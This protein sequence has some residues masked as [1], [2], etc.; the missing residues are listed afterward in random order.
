[1]VVILAEKPDQ[2]RK[3]ASPFPHRRQKNHIE[4][5]HCSL[6]KQGAT[7]VWAIGH[8]VT[9][10]EPERY[11]SNWKKWNLHDLPLIPESFQHQIVAEK[12][13]HYKEIKKHLLS[14]SEII[15]ATDPA[16]EGELIARWIIQMAG[17]TRK[18]IKRLW[19]SSLTSD[20]IIQAFQNLRTGKSTEP[21]YH[22]ALARSYSD[23]LV[24]MNASRVYTLLLQAKG[25]AGVF[26][27]G[28]VQT[29]LLTLIRKRE[30]EIENFKPE[31][32]W[33]LVGEFHTENEDLYTG[34]HRKRFTDRAEAYA[35]FE[36]LQGLPGVITDVTADLKRIAPPKLHSLS[37]LQTKMNRRFK[38]SPTQILNVVQGLYEKGY[39]SYPRTDSQYVGKAEA[40]T[41][42]ELLARLSA[43][44][45]I[46][47][48]PQK[49]LQNKRYVNDAKVTDHHAILPTTQ[50]PFLNKLNTN[51]RQVY[52]EIARSF[53][54]IHAPDYR[55]RETIIQTTVENVDFKSVG[56][57][58]IDFGWKKYLDEVKKEAKKDEMILPSVTKGEKVRAHISPKEG[59]TQAPKPYTEGQLIQLMKT[60]G[61]HIEDENIESKAIGLGT[62]ATRAGMI[63]TLKDR[64][65]IT[66]SKN[67]VMVTEK[68]KT[69]V[70]A[71]AGTP[72]AKP[73][74]TAKWEAYLIEIGQGKR[75]H[76]PFIERSK[77][78]AAHLVKHA[79]AQ[80]K[81][82]QIEVATTSAITSPIG[83]CPQCQQPLVAHQ[84]FY[85]CSG[86]RSGCKFSLPK[87]YCKK[88]ISPATV[89]RLLTKGKSNLLKGFVSKQGN[90]FDAFLVLKDGKIAF[91]FAKDHSTKSV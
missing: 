84:K 12:A 20:A 71:I 18:P 42:P 50:L 48:P 91:D 82:W 45:A 43:S 67:T 61:K 41:F 64:D 11:E 1:M 24:G 19:S 25:V 39:V 47:D 13:H 54:A 36:R 31:H 86:Y 75:S 32:F 49:V 85:G 51:E 77:A 27:A 52:D 60:A 15:I 88:K 34:K 7:V 66:V 35:L 23:W 90:K 37:T 10:A 62:E 56:R 81:T 53:I 68:G 2:A 72:L 30:V 8:L 3:L 17:A 87:Q 22:E 28:R 44:F 46:P 29:P 70:Q 65:Y 78:L 57:V 73:D 55:Y 79:T 5:Q 80:S 74:L 6:F 21:I 14:A 40:N 58:P 59:M 9:L 83:P 38:L 16:R 63:Q 76:L 33:E 26:S 69:L 89:K 4:I